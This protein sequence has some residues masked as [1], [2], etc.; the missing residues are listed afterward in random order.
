MSYGFLVLIPAIRY[1]LADML[2]YS[3]PF[4]HSGFYIFPLQPAFLRKHQ[5]IFKSLNAL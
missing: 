5:K 4:L 1:C 3:L 2:H